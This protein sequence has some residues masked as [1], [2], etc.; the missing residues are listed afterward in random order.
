MPGWRARS[1]REH[2]EDDRQAR[3]RHDHPD[4]QWQRAD[5]EGDVCEGAAWKMGIVLC[6][7]TSTKTGQ[8]THC[9][10]CKLRCHAL[11]LASSSTTGTVSLSTTIHGVCRR[12]VR[13]GE[14]GAHRDDGVQAIGVRRRAPL[15]GRERE[16]RARE[17]VHERGDRARQRAHAHRRRRHVVDEVCR[18]RVLCR[19]T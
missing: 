4:A 19:M 11:S 1:V 2:D 12:N 8:T 15:G 18:E 17:V 7:A 9:V 16:E 10:A 14:G 13:D 3:A 5:G 6:V